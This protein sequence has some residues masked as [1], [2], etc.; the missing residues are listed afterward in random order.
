MSVRFATS[1]CSSHSCVP[2]QVRDRFSSDTALLPG[3]D[4]AV[5]RVNAPPAMAPWRERMAFAAEI[6]H[7][8]EAVIAP[9]MAAAESRKRKPAPFPRPVPVDR[10]A[11]VVRA[12]GQI[13]AIG[14]EER[15]HG[16]TVGGKEAYERRFRHAA[17]PGQRI[18]LPVLVSEG[19]FAVALAA[20][21]V[22]V[23]IVN[24]L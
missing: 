15:R 24:L 16:I 21:H 10:L 17:E 22:H 2:A 8:I 6:G 7:R 3:I 19:E 11:R 23:A 5:T 20:S 4:C 14:A 1:S 18:R 13:A 12:R 9:G